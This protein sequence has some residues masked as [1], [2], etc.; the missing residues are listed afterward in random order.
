MCRKRNQLDLV[1][2]V[3]WHSILTIFTCLI[4]DF[5][6]IHHTVFRIFYFFFF[7]EFIYIWPIKMKSYNPIPS[8]PHSQLSVIPSNE[9]WYT[10]T[11]TYYICIYVVKIKFQLINIQRHNKTQPK[12]SLNNFVDCL[13]TCN[14]KK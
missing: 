6:I 3:L 4:Y 5:H 11:H 10:N 2:K 8:H 14:Q 9:K 13:M 1:S 7:G 12:S